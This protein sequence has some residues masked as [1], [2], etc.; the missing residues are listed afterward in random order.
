[1][2][3]R[4][5]WI[6]AVSGGIDSAVLLDMLVDSQTADLVVAHVDHGIRD[7]SSQDAE[8]VKLMAE[9]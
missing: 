3:E 9:K 5:T 6:V 1:M 7:D 2:S 8:L 4:E